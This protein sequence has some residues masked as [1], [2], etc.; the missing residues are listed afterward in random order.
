MDSKHNFDGQHCYCYFGHFEGIDGSGNSD[1]VMMTSRCHHYGYWVEGLLKFWFK[2]NKI[3]WLNLTKEAPTFL[4]WP[5]LMKFGICL[6]RRMPTPNPLFLFAEE[7]RLG[8]Y[9]HKT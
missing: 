5:L 3:N 1:L 8:N 6:V 7:T 2:T 9:G 4:M